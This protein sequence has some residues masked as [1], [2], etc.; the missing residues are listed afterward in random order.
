[1]LWGKKK[2]ED[3]KERQLKLLKNAFPSIRRPQNDDTLFEIRFMVDSQSFALRIFIPSDFPTMR[4]GTTSPLA[5]RSPHKA[6]SPL[7]SPFIIL[8][9]A[10]SCLTVLTLAHAVLQVAGSIEHPW[11]DQFKQVNGCN[12]VRL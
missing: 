12:R 3:E 8:H 10:A 4:P 5:L 9:R 6:L 7:C 1:M 11:L 2:T